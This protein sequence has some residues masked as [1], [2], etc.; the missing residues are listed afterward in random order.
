M[1]FATQTT[2]VAT[3]PTQ[4][5]GCRLHDQRRGGR[6][7]QCAADGRGAGHDTAAKPRPHNH[8]EVIMRNTVAGNDGRLSNLKRSR[9]LLL[10]TALAVLGTLSMTF[11][12]PAHAQEP[13]QDQAQV[14]CPAN[15]ICLYEHVNFGGRVAIYATG[16]AD[17]NRFGPRFNDMTSSIINNTGSR[18]CAYEHANYG[19]QVLVIAPRQRRPTLPGWNDRISSLR[20]C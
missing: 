5:T 17:M 6:S 2:L 4:Q 8:Q 13:A 18:W 11:A 9:R 15:R 3:T 1:T 19:G 12:P 16:S 10:T 7:A 14:A 20:R